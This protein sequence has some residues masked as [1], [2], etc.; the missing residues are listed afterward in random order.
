MEKQTGSGKQRLQG[1]RIAILAT[2]G[3]EQSELEKPR[4]AFDSEGAKTVIV[5]PK[6][7][8]IQGYHH[9]DK[10]DTF[11]VDQSLEQADVQSFDALLL[12][13]GVINPDQL[14]MLP[15]AVDFVRNFAKSEKPIFAICHGPWTLV[16][17]DVVRGRKVTS[18]PSVKTDLKN[19]GATWVDQEVVSDRGII[20]SR[21]PDDIPAF[22]EKAIEELSAS[23][24]QTAQ[25][26]H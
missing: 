14:R 9:F 21:K 22:V 13:G 6:I 12:P 26:T 10:S 7:G 23:R 1:K 19:A 3:F 2:D 4:A 11:K 24:A 5:S 17:A 18:W 8:Q 20:T 25:P 16:E 15:K